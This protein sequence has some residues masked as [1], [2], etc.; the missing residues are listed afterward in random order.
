MK[1]LKSFGLFENSSP[2]LQLTKNVDFDLIHKIQ[3]LIKSDTILEISCGNGA[4]AL[5]LSEHG[6]DVTAT[7]NNS[8]YVDFVDQFIDCYLH[9]TKNKFPF[10]DEQFDLVYSRLGLHYFT[11]QEL[12]NIF[13]EISRITKKYLVYSVKLVNDIQAGKVIL[14]EHTWLELTRDKFEILSSEVK[15]GLLYGNESK[16]LEVVAIK[17]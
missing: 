15:T 17:K 7:D 9:D 2:L 11:P 12:V 3:S 8:E 14:D 1:H 4:D 10:K 6:F 5:Y 13:G 16:W